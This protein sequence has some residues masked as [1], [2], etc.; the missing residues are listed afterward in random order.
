M[1][2]FTAENSTTKHRK[3]KLF[4][5]SKLA[6]FPRFVNENKIARKEN[7]FLWLK[8]YSDW[9]R[10]TFQIKIRRTVLSARRA[11]FVVDVQLHVK[12]QRTQFWSWRRLWNALVSLERNCKVHSD[13]LS[14]LSAFKVAR[15]LTTFDGTCTT[16]T[17]FLP[18]S[19]RPEQTRLHCSEKISIS[20]TN[21]LHG[22]SLS[23]CETRMK[24]ERRESLLSNKT[25]NFQVNFD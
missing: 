18:S 10:K 23:T 11:R 7:I 6:S 2:L 20:A 16:S 12:Y 21:V 17:K 14:M 4:P 24:I 3:K 15:E 5:V 19:L 22:C 1:K 25:T 8:A 13:D 9:W